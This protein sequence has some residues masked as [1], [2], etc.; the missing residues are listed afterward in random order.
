MEVALLDSREYQTQLETLYLTALAL[1]LNRFEFQMQWFLV[2]NTNFTHFGSG[3]TPNGETNTLTSNTDFGFSRNFAAG[4]QFLTDFA[5]SLVYE[6]TGGT[7]TVKSNWLFSLVQPLLRRA[8]RKVRLESLTQQERNVLYSVRT[9]ARFRKQFWASVAMGNGSNSGY[10]GLL[11]SLQ[12]LRNQEANLK[13]QENLSPA[14]RAVS[15]RSTLCCRAGSGL[16]GV[17]AGAAKV[18]G[19]KPRSTRSSTD[20]NC[21][22]ACRPTA[23]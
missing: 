21:C 14:Q 3:G 16:F 4:G 11:L 7:Q 2:N 12:T 18:E 8:G 19:L 1:T 17:A 22:S 20:S 6:Y 5:N 9:F 15:G 10:L 23:D 13:R